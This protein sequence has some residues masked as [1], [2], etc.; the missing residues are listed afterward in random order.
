M[1]HRG[2]VLFRKNDALHRFVES[3]EAFQEVLKHKG[4][5]GKLLEALDR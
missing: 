2:F 4:D 3:K 5:K 1:Q